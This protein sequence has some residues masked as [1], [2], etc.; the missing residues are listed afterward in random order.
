MNIREEPMKIID[1][2]IDTSDVQIIG[3]IVNVPDPTELK[4]T[5]KFFESA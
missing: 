3:E 4:K 5:G 1:I 2:S